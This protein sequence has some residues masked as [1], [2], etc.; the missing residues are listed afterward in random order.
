MLAP[1]NLKYKNTNSIECIVCF[2][3]RD[4]IMDLHTYMRYAVIWKNRQI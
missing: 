2:E 3:T 4:L 1:I